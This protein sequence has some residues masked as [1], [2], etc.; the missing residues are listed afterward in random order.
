MD[1]AGL[2]RRRGVLLYGGLVPLELSHS[3]LC[4]IIIPI[5]REK[6]KGGRIFFAA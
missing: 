5:S 4:D 1:Q 3:E 6:C 2:P